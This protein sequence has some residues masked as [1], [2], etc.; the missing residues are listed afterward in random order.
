MKCREVFMTLRVKTIFRKYGTAALVLMAAGVQLG[1]SYLFGQDELLLSRIPDGD[2]A[3]FSFSPG[4]IIESEFLN[5]CIESDSAAQAIREHGLAAFEGISGVRIDGINNVMVFVSDFHSAIPTIGALASG[6]FSGLNY[7]IILRALSVPS[8]IEH[9]IKVNGYNVHVYS[10]QGG[11]D[12]E[13]NEIDIDVEPHLYFDDEEILIAGSREFIEQLLWLKDGRGS[14]LHDNNEFVDQFE[15]IRDNE[16]FWF[17]IPTTKIMDDVMEKVLTETEG[18]FSGERLD[19]TGVVGGFTFS[20]TFDMVLQLHNKNKDQI[21]HL[22]NLVNGLRSLA[23]LGVMGV[24][25]MKELTSYINSIE[26][27]KESG[28][29]QLRLEL[30][31]KQIEELIVNLEEAGID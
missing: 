30:T 2:F 9:L 1:P 13:E 15:H 24:P 14:N 11:N 29:L 3:V 19:I 8:N 26:L 28:F 6:D 25:E 10:I 20:D 4:D 12:E 23:I 27:T 22:Y 5:Y 31:I 17:V 18:L 21:E 7:D 16:S